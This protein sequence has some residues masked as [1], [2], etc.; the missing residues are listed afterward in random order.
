MR[1]ALSLLLMAIPAASG[2]AEPRREALIARSERAAGLERTPGNRLDCATLRVE[3]AGPA[4]PLGARR[5]DELPAGQLYHAVERQ[6]DGCRELVLVSEER[7][8]R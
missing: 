1:V 7:G 6:V 2:M 8:R 3:H 5:L 4:A